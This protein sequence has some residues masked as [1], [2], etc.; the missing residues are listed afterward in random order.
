MVTLHPL[1]KE[2]EQLKKRAEQLEERISQLERIVEI[3]KLD[4]IADVR[5]IEVLDRKGYKIKRIHKEAK[6]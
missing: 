3:L 6:D 4:R 5:A 1:E 2:V